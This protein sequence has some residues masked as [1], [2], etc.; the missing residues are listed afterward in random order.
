MDAANNRWKITIDSS[1]ERQTGRA[2][3]PCRGR[4]QDG[5]TLQQRQRGYDAHQASARTHH[6]DGL[7]NAGEHT[8]FLLRHGNEHRQRGAEV[9]ETS[10]DTTEEDRD[11]Q[12]A[13]RIAD[14]IAHDGSQIK[15]DQAVADGAKSSKKT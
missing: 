2:A 9:D 1:N 6:V 8:N 3:E 10:N 4:A 5:N 13:A 14:L 15:P 11:G 7:Q 12:I